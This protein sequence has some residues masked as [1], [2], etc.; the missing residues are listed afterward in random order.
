M[1]Q[2]MVTLR[3][4]GGIEL[5]GS[6][7]H[8]VRSI[9]AQPRRL[10]LLLYLAVTNHERFTRKDTVRALFWP[11]ADN[12][13][14]RQSL[15]RAVHVLRQAVG[16]EIITT[17]GDEEIGLAKD[18]IQCDV[19][20][21]QRALEAGALETALELYRGD[22]APGFL[23]TE[24]PEFERWLEGERTRVQA[25]ALQA[26]RSLTDR[27]EADGNLVLAAHWAQRTTL[28]G[29]YDERA[30]TR[31]MQVLDRLG[32]RAA[33]LKAFE[34]FERRLKLDLDIEPSPETLDLVSRLRARRNSRRMP[35]PRQKAVR[36]RS[37]GHLPGPPRIPERRWIL[38][39]SLAMIGLVVG[40][41]AWLFRPRLLRLT[42]SNAIPIT[43]EPGIEF[44][45]SLSPD[46]SLVAFTSIS[47]GHRVIDLRSTNATLAGTPVRLAGN[48]AEDETLPTW[49]ED[50]SRVRYASSPFPARFPPVSG[51]FEIS[52]TGGERRALS[53]PRST[54]WVSWS[55]DGRR[56]AF[57]SGDSIFL[58]SNADHHTRLLV[59][60]SGSGWKP[61]SLTWSP[62]EHWI[63]YVH[64]N[65]LWAQGWNTAPSAIWL[66]EVESGVRVAV[67]D[68]THLNV[69]PVWL[70]PSHLLFVSDRDGRREV[71]LAD[72][73]AAGPRGTATKIP[74]GTDAHS[75][76]VSR[77][78]RKLAIARFEG[79]QNV[80]SY[81][82]DSRDSRP[83]AGRQPVLSAARWWKPMISRPTVNGWPMTPTCT[84]TPISTKS[85]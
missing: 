65:H 2:G 79:R 80:W 44:Q 74:G 75:I 55:R 36:Q 1:N 9:L 39:S 29:P 16:N 7:G 19:V 3:M 34:E 81:P 26:A 47:G 32:D 13:H 49:S 83:G 70:D 50:G 51:E 23:P 57:A 20:E 5:I 46:G 64:G 14:A 33:A 43:S 68:E 18:R 28:L 41:S 78:G 22:L 84:V 69:S 21:F 60:H 73:G 77:D 53:F 6:D 42:T 76:S 45:P 48:A 40:I 82:I 71:Y 35:E 52:R 67:T 62:D 85:D 38:L 56:V 66:V 17:R 63:A 24:L 27:E 12:Q 15:N 59:V 61:H 10:A 31:R 4:L 58:H 37:P 25:Q 11:E 72:I 8:P 54:P 30:A